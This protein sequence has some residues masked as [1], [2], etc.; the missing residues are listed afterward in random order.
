[1]I[2]SSKPVQVTLCHQV[3][4]ALS[5]AAFGASQ[6]YFALF[7]PGHTRALLLGRLLIRRALSLRECPAPQ[8]KTHLNHK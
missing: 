3:E 2:E 6:P 5:I 7:L 8:S 4:I 1:M